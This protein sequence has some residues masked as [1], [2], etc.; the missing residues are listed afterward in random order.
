MGAGD[1]DVSHIDHRD[2]PA[3]IKHGY[4]VDMITQLGLAV[5]RWVAH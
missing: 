2:A 3:M 4:V 1:G 5:S